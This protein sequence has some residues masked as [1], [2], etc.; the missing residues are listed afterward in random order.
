MSSGFWFFLSA[1]LVGRTGPRARG[2]FRSLP[3]DATHHTPKPPCSW[4]GSGFEVGIVCA[5][6][7]RGF[8]PPPSSISPG[9]PLIIRTVHQKNCSA[10]LCS[11]CSL[12]PLVSPLP[13]QKY[14][15]ASLRSLCCSTPGPQ[16]GPMAPPSSSDFLSLLKRKL[17]VNVGAC[18]LGVGVLCLSPSRRLFC[19]VRA[20]QVRHVYGRWL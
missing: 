15:S 5:R 19:F 16:P 17:C 20:L 10:A 18:V 11:L 12:P 9:P 7:V 1:S 8:P 14:C 6:E 4:S 13:S 3:L 2:R